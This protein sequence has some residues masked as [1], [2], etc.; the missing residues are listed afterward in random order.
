M[1]LEPRN[2]YKQNP[3]RRDPVAPDATGH[4]STSRP[5]RINSEFTRPIQIDRPKQ[6]RPTS[7]GPTRRVPQF[8]HVL[9]SKRQY[10]CVQ[11]E[12]NPYQPCALA[13]T[14]EAVGSHTLFHTAVGT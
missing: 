8:I 3:V 9:Q 1:L 11:R 12:S 13:T 2:N 14:N 6:T 4:N 7:H 10:P 5:D